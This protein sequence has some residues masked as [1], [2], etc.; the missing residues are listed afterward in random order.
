MPRSP[1]YPQRLLP[2]QSRRADWRAAGRELDMDGRHA[3]AYA[4]RWLELW[5]V[6]LDIAREQEEWE[7]AHLWLIG[8][9]V[10]ARRL[11][12]EHQHA[13]DTDGR[14]TT[15][16]SGRTFAHPGI[17]KARDARRESRELAA[18]LG[19]T[20]KAIRDAGYS[21]DDPDDDPQGDQAGL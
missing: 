16:D 14:Y 20:P 19:I 15:T 10:E 6:I 12:H 9:Y 5:R 13:A 11:A 18:E 21:D 2:S 3:A 17:D 4:Q 7:E 1:K 8:D